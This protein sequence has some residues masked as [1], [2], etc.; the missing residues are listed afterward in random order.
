MK[1]IFFCL[2]VLFSCPVFA[3]EKEIQ[4]IKLSQVI[5]GAGRVNVTLNTERLFNVDSSSHFYQGVVKIRGVEYPASGAKINGVLKI[6]F[7]GKITGS[8]ASRQRFYTIK[9]TNKIKV[10][11]APSSFFSQKEC[12]S[13]NHQPSV[14]QHSVVDEAKTFR[15]LTISTYAD[16]EFQQIYGAQT[17]A[18]IA[19]IINSSEVIYKNQL[20]IKFNI[21]SQTLLADSTPTLAPGEILSEFR[22][23]TKTVS[24]N[25]KHLFTG[26]DMSSS[27]V[28]IAYVSAVCFAPDYAHGVTQYYGFYTNNIFAHEIGHNLGSQHDLLGYGTLMYPTISLGEVYFSQF[29][30][31]QINSHLSYFGTCLGQETEPSLFDG[32][33]LSL[34]QIKQH[35]HIKFVDRNGSPLQ[36]EKLS[37]RVFGKTTI[38]TTSSAGRVL[39]RLTRRGAYYVSARSLTRPSIFSRIKVKVK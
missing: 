4:P 26:K 25:L 35:V 11:S 5:R 14:V 3:Q 17:N 8:R 22:N 24:A 6:N 19:A 20:S 30:I 1:H 10:A 9:V 33:T 32:A 31:E 21:V 15:V 29:S 23:N 28:G 2:F 39:I 13:Q 36:N 34:T 27:V 12:G 38:K 7:P 18:E 16:P 37:I